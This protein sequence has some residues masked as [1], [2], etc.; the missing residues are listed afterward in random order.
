[1]NTKVELLSPAGNLHKLKISLAFGADA[2]YGGVSHFSLRNRSGREFDDESFKDGVAYAHSMGKK[3]YATVNGFPYNSQI[4]MY[5]KHLEKMEEFGVDAIIVATPGVVKLAKRSA[6]KTPIHLSTQANVMNKIDAE[7]YAD[8]G[9]SR[10]IAAREVSL[11]DLEEIKKHLPNLELEVFIHGSMCFA[12][13]GRC[14]ISTLQTGRIPNRGSCANDC[15]FPYEVY[16]KNSDSN[17][18]LKI[19]DEGE[20]GS[21]IFNAKDLNMSSHIDEILKSG[22]ID[23]LKIEGRTKS[24]YYAAITARTYRQAIDDFYNGTY[25]PDFYQDELNTLKNR[26]YSDGYLVKRPYEKHDTQE[27]SFA[28]SEGDFDVCGE[29]NSDKI[30]FL[31]K[32]TTIPDTEYELIAPKE[33]IYTQSDIG[34]IYKKE[35]KDYIRF[36]KILTQNGKELNSVHSGNTNPIILPG[37]LP[38]FTFF[39]RRTKE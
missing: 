4:A 8:M 10:I 9:V 18:M 29:V 35:G 28:Q 25:N 14:L 23:S 34:E 36:N 6:P 15:R 17:Q 37:E 11:K 31:C 21:Y 19:V 33:V 32:H 26:G 7:V 16:V 22:V 13:S 20:E 24:D 27:L 12:Y 30:T 39:R 2:V 1:L 5:E 3:V 38:E